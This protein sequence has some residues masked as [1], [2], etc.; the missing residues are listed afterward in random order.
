M[1]GVPVSGIVHMRSYLPVTPVGWGH[2]LTFSQP[3]FL[4]LP[5]FQTNDEDRSFAERW[6]YP[7]SRV[8]F[9]NS[10]VE[11]RPLDVSLEFGLGSEEQ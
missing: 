11:N 10:Q 4:S 8:L 6:V 7:T 2:N 9:E 5:S 3:V 1:G